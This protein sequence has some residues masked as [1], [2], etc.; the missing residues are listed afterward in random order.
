[1]SDTAVDELTDKD[2]KKLEKKYD[3][4]QEEKKLPKETKIE[5]FDIRAKRAQLTEQFKLV[6][7]L[8]KNNVARR[9]CEAQLNQLELQEA[10]K[11]NGTMS[12]EALRAADKLMDDAG[13]RVPGLKGVLGLLNGVDAVSRYLVN[14]SLN[15]WIKSK[16]SRDENLGKVIHGTS[17]SAGTV[18]RLGKQ[19]TDKITTALGVGAGWLED[20]GNKTIAKDGK[21]NLDFLGQASEGLKGFMHSAEKHHGTAQN[22]A[23]AVEKMF[24]KGLTAVA[25]EENIDGV[26]QAVAAQ[27]AKQTKGPTPG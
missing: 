5:L 3:F 16:E 19:F 23:N 13:F 9:A 10:Q 14:S 26:T 1:M 18:V 7:D 2:I 20:L 25:G 27:K 17:K 4:T 6:K 24:T 8:G 21:L 22:V 12:P 15:D 11:I